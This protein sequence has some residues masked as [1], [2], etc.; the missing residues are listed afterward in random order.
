MLLRLFPLFQF[1]HTFIHFKITNSHQYLKHLKVFLK[2][3]APTCFGPYLRPSLGGSW[4]VLCAFTN[5]PPEDGRKYGPKHVGA[6]FFKS[7]FK[8]FNY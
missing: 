8:C 5:E 1:M 3:L 6:S 4:A 7:V 2:K